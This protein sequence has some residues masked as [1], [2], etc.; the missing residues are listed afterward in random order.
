MIKIIDKIS[1][2]TYSTTEVLY[3]IKFIYKND[4]ICFHFRNYPNIYFRVTNYEMYSYY[5]EVGDCY[6]V[7]MDINNCIEN[8]FYNTTKKI[9]INASL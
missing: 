1:D 9:L 6:L 5:I 4:N 3:H 7:K 8:L 2:Y